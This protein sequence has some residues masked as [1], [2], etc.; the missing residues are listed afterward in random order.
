MVVAGPRAVRYICKAALHCHGEQIAAHAQPAGD[1]EPA[2][3]MRIRMPAHLFA[4]EVHD[5]LIVESFKHQPRRCVE[6]RL[7]HVEP[8]AVEPPL[9]FHPAR[10]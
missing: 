1:L 6:V 5:S 9:L 4:I 7:V 10:C 2:R 8:A 3:A